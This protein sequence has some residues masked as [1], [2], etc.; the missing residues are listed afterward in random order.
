MIQCVTGICGATDCDSSGGCIYMSNPGSCALTTCVNGVVTNYDA[1]GAPGM[2]NG[3]KNGGACPGNVA[4]ADASTCK[5]SC[6]SDS[7]C[8]SPTA[9]CVNPGPSG[10]CAQQGTTNASCGANDQCLSGFCVA[11]QCSP[12]YLLASLGTG[13]AHMCAIKLA[14]N[15][16]Y[17]WG[18]N[19]AGALGNASTTDS[20]VAVAVSGGHSFASISVSGAVSPETTCAIDTSGNGFC[21]GDNGNEE[22]GNGT[23]T[24]STT[25]T[26]ISGGLGFSQLAV[27]RYYGC[28]IATSTTYCW[29]TGTGV[30]APSSTPAQLPGAPA[31]ASLA[32]GNYVFCG[33]DGNG[34]AYCY[35][36][37]NRGQLGN[38]GEGVSSQVPQP[39]I[40]GHTFLPSSLTAGSNH[41]CGIDTTGQ[42]WCWGANTEGELGNGTGVDSNLPVLVSGGMTWRQIV[43]G[44]AH[45]CAIASSSQ[46]YCW[47]GSGAEGVLGNGTNTFDQLSPVPVPNYFFT[48]LAAGG[49][50]TCGVTIQGTV[51]CWGNN[52]NGQL[53]NGT[54]TN[55]NV[56]VA[57]MNLP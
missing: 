11:G 5:S 23:M 24:G 3:V 48:Q 51:M 40:G 55:S 57:V 6:L 37:N 2:C 53:G 10:T 42:P 52:S 41:A 28:G 49:E 16:A 18:Y 30:F 14:T 45:T 56:P 29:G 35:G 19:E 26:P 47:G 9:Y 33:L 34:A 39:V 12:G 15:Q 4:C 22:F 8:A 27:S 50:M 44:S 54:T 32:G 13:A 31:F 7:D 46:A 43:A 38:G 17:C 21:W 20:S 1:C 25:P 36:D